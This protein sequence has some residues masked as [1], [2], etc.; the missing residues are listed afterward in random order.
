M[1]SR[2]DTTRLEHE[3]R[4]VMVFLIKKKEKQKKTVTENLQHKSKEID[5]ASILN[6]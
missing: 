3:R 1:I 4:K 5:R 6:R 2:N